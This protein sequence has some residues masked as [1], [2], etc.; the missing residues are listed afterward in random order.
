MMIFLK[1]TK[2]KKLEDYIYRVCQ[3]LELFNDEAIIDIEICPKSASLNVDGYCH[4]DDDHVNVSI[5]RVVE[6]RE[7]SLE[8]MK[9]TIAHEM[10]HAKQYA[11]ARLAQFELGNYLYENTVYKNIAYE[12]QPWEKEAYKLESII[13]E[14]CR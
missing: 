10:V 14:A 6:G 2:S 9:L 13:Y 12:D 11:S 4:G 8:E 3:Y 7:V 5:A 1:G